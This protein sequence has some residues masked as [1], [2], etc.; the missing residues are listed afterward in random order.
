MTI[1][2]SLLAPVEGMPVVMQNV[3]GEVGVP[4]GADAVM[5]IVR[6][7]PA[8]AYVKEETVPSTHQIS[9]VLA[10]SDGRLKGVFGGSSALPCG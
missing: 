8:V 7:A 1:S 5:R 3:W 6:E 4:M 2:Q 10:V 9:R